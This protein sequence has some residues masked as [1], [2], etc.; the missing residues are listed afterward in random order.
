MIIYTSSNILLTYN[1]DCANVWLF[2]FILLIYIYIAS[3]LARA[4]NILFINK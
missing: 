1:Y 4:I 3:A 2:N